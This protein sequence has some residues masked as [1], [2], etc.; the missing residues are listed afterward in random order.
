MKKFRIC[1]IGCGY[2]VQKYGVVYLDGVLEHDW[3]NCARFD[4]LETAEEYLE[5]RQS[6]YD[7]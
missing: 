4:D 5:W 7:D 6:S 3:K 1:K 2:Y